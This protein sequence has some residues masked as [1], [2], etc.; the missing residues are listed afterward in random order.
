M[1]ESKIG[2]ESLNIV[3][4]KDVEIVVLDDHNETT[5]DGKN[6]K[7]PEVHQLDTMPLIDARVQIYTELISML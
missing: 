1:K 3:P 2:D 5:N 4:I 7:T 6:K